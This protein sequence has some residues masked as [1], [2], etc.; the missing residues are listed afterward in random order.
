MGTR[1][2]TIKRVLRLTR[3]MFFR[4]GT[5]FMI[6]LLTGTLSLVPLGIS[7]STGNMAIVAAM[8][9]SGGDGGGDGGGGD[10]GG[11]DTPQSLAVVGARRHGQRAE[12]TEG[13]QQRQEEQEPYEASEE[14]APPVS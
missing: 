5:L 2:K 14:P 12:D 8:A 13:Q 7:R 3:R 4:Y 11:G 6:L 9:D 10:G 1:Q